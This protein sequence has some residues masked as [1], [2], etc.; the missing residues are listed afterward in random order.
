MHV[1]TIVVY[2]LPLSLSVILILADVLFY[3]KKKTDYI[4]VLVIFS[5]AKIKK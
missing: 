2:Y 5:F 4:I 1:G 3:S